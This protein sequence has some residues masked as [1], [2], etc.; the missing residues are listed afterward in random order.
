MSNSAQYQRAVTPTIDNALLN[1]TSNNMNIGGSGVR[2]KVLNYST[3]NNNSVRNRM[4]NALG[5][6]PPLSNSSNVSITSV[7]TYSSLRGAAMNGNVIN[8][9]SP[10]TNVG[11]AG[12]S[13]GNF[14]P[15]MGEMAITGRASGVNGPSV[16]SHVNKQPSFRLTSDIPSSGGQSPAL[17]PN[18]SERNHTASLTALLPRYDLELLQDEIPLDGILFARPKTSTSSTTS[19]TEDFP[20]IVFRT[21]EERLRNPERLNLD[22]R[23]L[24]RCPSLE[25][26]TRLRLLN[27]QN[28]Q[29]VAIENLEALPNLIFL[30]LYNNRLTSLQGYVLTY[31]T[32]IACLLC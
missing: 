4:G 27:Y 13:L 7:N 25:Q 10:R 9:S 5:G 3:A 24:S 30:D 20:L 29:I 28:N 22:R 17:P 15:A 18:H 26:E 14:S 31:L 23:N 19:K 32:L 1:G 12:L 6:G 21:P 11:I 2:G 16:Y 8:S